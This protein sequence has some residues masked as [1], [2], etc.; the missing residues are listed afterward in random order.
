VLFLFF[1]FFLRAE[2]QMPLHVSLARIESYVHVKPVYIKEHRFIKTLLRLIT[3]HSEAGENLLLALP[4]E[5]QEGW[6]CVRPSGV[7]YPYL[8]KERKSS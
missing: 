8:Y 3:A 5:K 7:C 2:K 1:H 6:I 4:T